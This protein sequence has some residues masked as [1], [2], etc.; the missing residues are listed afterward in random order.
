[1]E[2]V[3]DALRIGVI[4]EGFGVAHA[5]IHL[6][7]LRGSGELLKKGAVGVTDPEFSVTAE[8]IKAE[9]GRQKI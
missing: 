6:I 3:T 8:K 5:H 7:P 4:V 2:A 1:M 9:I